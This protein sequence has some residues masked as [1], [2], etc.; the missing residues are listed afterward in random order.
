M[1]VSPQHDA[2]RVELREACRTT[3]LGPGTASDVVPLCTSALFN[4]KPI[5]RRETVRGGI[6]ESYELK[7]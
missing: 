1:N 3:W 6:A 4:W 5:V 2:H 7:F